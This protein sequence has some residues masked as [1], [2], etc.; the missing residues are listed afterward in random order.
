MVGQMPAWI[1]S[2]LRLAALGDR[3]NYYVCNMMK[4]TVDVYGELESVRKGSLTRTQRR[5]V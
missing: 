5:S 4:H 1:E 3:F 2:M